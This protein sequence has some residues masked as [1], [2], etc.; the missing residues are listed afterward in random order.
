MQ[1]LGRHSSD[2]LK[3]SAR[4]L[5]PGGNFL[6]QEPLLADAQE[7]KVVSILGFLKCRVGLQS[8]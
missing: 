6:A 3:E 2:F 5:K 4:V 1:T 8:F 7:L